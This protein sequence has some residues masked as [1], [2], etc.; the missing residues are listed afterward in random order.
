MSQPSIL[1]AGK[2][3]V[4]R[5][6]PSKIGWAMASAVSPS[7]SAAAKATPRPPGAAW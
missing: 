7:S 1:N 5:W 4:L 3:T 6:R 2:A